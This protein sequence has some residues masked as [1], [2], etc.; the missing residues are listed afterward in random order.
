MIW[1]GFY[2]ILLI[3]LRLRLTTSTASCPTSSTSLPAPSTGDE[4]IV[5]RRRVCW[6]GSRRAAF[7]SGIP[8]TLSTSSLCL[9]DGGLCKFSTDAHHSPTLVK[10]NCPLSLLVRLVTMRLCRNILPAPLLCVLQAVG[11]VL[12]CFIFLL[13]DLN[14]EAII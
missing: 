13:T 7:C 14:C 12:L 5:M 8:S 9:L 10:G 4:W 6:Q 1:I 3:F 2:F 11:S